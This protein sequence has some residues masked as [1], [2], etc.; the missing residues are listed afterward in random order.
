MVEVR[1][2]PARDL[3]EPVKLL[4]ESMRGG[5]PL[6]RDFVELLGEEVERG[7]IEVLTAHKND[8]VIGVAVLAFRSSISIG[9]RFASIEDL[10]VKPE[11]RREG[12][13][14]AILEVAEEI[15]VSKSVSYVEAQVVE[16]EAVSFYRSLGYEPEPGVRVLSRSILL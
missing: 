11:A 3:A 13:G 5:D 16:E 7:G 1:I 2:T 12:V 8:S 9:D 4:E 15:C 10:Y 14:R 6:P